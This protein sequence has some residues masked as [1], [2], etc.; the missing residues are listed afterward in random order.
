[1]AAALILALASTLLLRGISGG[2]SQVT[3]APKVKTSPVVVAA[4]PVSAGNILTRDDVKEVDWPAEFLPAEQGFENID[5][6]VGRPTRVDLVPGE[7]VF[8][9]KLAG[10]DS[11]GGL[12]VM[13]PRGMRAT[14]VAVS[15][16]KGVAG[17]LRPGDKVDILATTES[18]IIPGEDPISSTHTVLQNVLV[19]ATAQTMANSALEDISPPE[20]VTADKNIK[21]LTGQNGEAKTSDKATSATKRSERKESGKQDAEDGSEARIVRSVT[22]ALWP[23]DA[24]KMTL[25]EDTGIIRLVLRPEGEDAVSDLIATT[26][27]DLY[28]AAPLMS[29]SQ[30][31]EP[32]PQ[33][34]SG[35]RVATRPVSR[36]TE[37]EFIE[38]S[39]KSTLS[40]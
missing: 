30:P 24:Q 4:L 19:L 26:S 20:G 25:A 9:I 3:H 28:N 5:D 31:P 39:N 32:A 6:V 10:V 12:P 18:E 14:T 16:V 40:F 34:P 17:F 22:L 36:G 15:E 35:T 29:F 7:P 27:L 11:L 13:I 2:K 37:V 33:A 21:N 1:M 8:R 23:G 38:G